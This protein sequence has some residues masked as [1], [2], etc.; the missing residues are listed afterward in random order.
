[1]AANIGSSQRL[2]YA[3]VGDTVN[4]ASRFEGVSKE[5]GWDI[6]LSASTRNALGDEFRYESLQ[7]VQI[8]GIAGPVEVFALAGMKDHYRRDIG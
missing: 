2:S 8:K 3:L 5:L 6:I 4:L 1:L 7:T